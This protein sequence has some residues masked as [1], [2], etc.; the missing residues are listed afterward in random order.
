V[1]DLE[2]HDGWRSFLH[3]WSQHIAQVYDLDLPPPLFQRLAGAAE[4]LRQP[5]PATSPA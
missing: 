2:L 4:P 5:T 1:R 3:G